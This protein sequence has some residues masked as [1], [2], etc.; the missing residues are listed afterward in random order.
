MSSKSLS[1]Q[2][3]GTYCQVA[4]LVFSAPGQ[5]FGRT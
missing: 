5:L 3:T 2:R 4:T 1:H